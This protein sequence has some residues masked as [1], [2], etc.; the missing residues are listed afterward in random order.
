[1]NSDVS[2][3]RFFRVDLVANR[4]KRPD[5]DGRF[6]PLPHAKCRAPPTCAEFFSEYLV[7]CHVLGRGHRDRRKVIPRVL[8]KRARVRDCPA[9][10]RGHRLGVE[11]QH[12]DIGGKCVPHAASDFPGVGRDGDS[13]DSGRDAFEGVVR[14]EEEITRHLHRNQRAVAF[15]G[16]DDNELSAGDFVFAFHPSASRRSVIHVTRSFRTS[17][18]LVSL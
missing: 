6:G 15:F 12:H 5:D 18:R 9:N 2:S 4:L 3:C 13:F 11:P 1:M 7:E 16:L 14:F 10:C 8:R 17:S